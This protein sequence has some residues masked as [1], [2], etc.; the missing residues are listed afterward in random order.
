MGSGAR[1]RRS[2]GLKLGAF[3]WL[4]L[5]AAAGVFAFA[6]VQLVGVIRAGDEV[7]V[8]AATAVTATAAPANPAPL[9][10]PPL[11]LRSV[12]VLP[13]VNFGDD[14]DGELFADGLTEELIHGLAQLGE[15][16]VAGRTSAFYFKGRNE[17]L[18]EVG[19]KL[20]VA[21]VLE[22]SVRRVGQQLR[23]TAQLIKVVDGFHL[24]SETFDQSASDVFGVQTRIARAV[25]E[26]LKIRLID[27]ALADSAPKRDPRAWPL[28]L[29]A[30]S[31]LRTRE[32]A[33]LQAA[34]DQYRELTQ[35]EPRNARGYTGFAEASLLLTQAH[36]AL[37]F[38][39]AHRESE[40]AV[41]TALKLAPNDASAWRVRGFLH[42]V[43]AIRGSD[44]KD[45]QEA[46][47]SFQR[48]VELDPRDADALTMYAAQRLTFRQPEEAS[49]LLRQAL[50]IDPLSRLT[51]QLLGTALAEQGRIGEAV[52]QY[53]NLISLYPD[54]TGARIALGTLQLQNGR[55]EEAARTFD[56]PEV[57][58]ADPLG[59]LMLAVC[60]ANL[61]LDDDF[62]KLL[63]GIQSPAIAASMAQGILL[64][65]DKRPAD[66][67]RFVNT[68]LA[69]TQDP[70]WRTSILVGAV[71]AGDLAEE[72]RQIADRTNPLWQETPA[73]G[74]FTPLDALMFAEAL[75]HNGEPV[76]AARIARTL[77]VRNEA[78]P[79]EYDPPRQ[80]WARFLAAA[81][82]GDNARAL[83]EL[84]SAEQSG[85]R[86]LVDD[87]YLMRLE[88]YPFVKPLAHDPRFVAVVRRIE[89]DNRKQRDQLLASRKIG[90]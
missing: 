81:S 1:R 85:F 6:T 76:Q 29:S 41:E 8:P 22:G 57:T 10:L 9:A 45:S 56:H 63:R 86:M 35:L 31:R 73:L 67:L 46:L 30:R 71:L 18:R 13:F 77:L 80:R 47:R 65:K 28:E 23:I 26:A 49:A 27:A 21:H 58:E 3:D 17:D 88:D 82:L 48:A 74:D 33:D 5:T 44:Q 25:A 75:K 53:D 11:P 72:R 70:A 39:Q 54:F 79:T 34:R 59:S 87:D 32:L 78:G 36:M 12:A 55:I 37:D 24:W 52:R 64:L 50:V 2:E 7:E 90:T 19:R 84:E 38:E 14:R 83:R 61:K 20:G 42:R 40:R 89:A 62:R 66:F 51:Q 16:H 43:L 68:Q 4:L 60:Y 69:Q 15:L